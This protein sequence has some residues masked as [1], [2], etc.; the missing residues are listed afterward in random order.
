M[1]SFLA[2]LSVAR[3]LPRQGLASKILLPA[4]S[5][6][7]GVGLVLF[8]FFAD[9]FARQAEEDLQNRLDSFLTTQAAELEG[10]V[11][12]FDQA[13]IDRLFRSYALSSD[14]QLARLTDARGKI[15]A[16]TGQPAPAGNRVFAAG[17]ELTRQ[18]GQDTYQLGRL[19]VVFNDSRIRQGLA[20]SR[21]VELPAAFALAVLFMAV[22][23]LTVHWQVGVPLR[24]LRES[25]E[26]NAATGQR[27]PLSW[28]SGDELGQVVGAYNA[29]LAE[30]N[31]QTGTLERANSE[32]G[33]ENLQRR[34]AEKRLTLY[35]TM[36]EATDTAMVITD[37]E[38]RVQETNAA[39]LRV[40]GFSAGE[41]AGRTVWETFLSDH[42]AQRVAEL[43]RSL[44]TGAGWAGE[45][46]GLTRRGGRVPLRL[47]INALAFDGD[48]ASHHVIVFA[49]ISEQKATQK[50]LKSLAYSDS[51]TGLPNRALFM[52]RLEREICIE[53]RRGR[54]FALL[55]VDLDNFKW[56]N[57]SLSHA[58][59]D[60]VLTVMAGRMKACLR[61][62]DTLARMGGDEFTVILRETSDAE[63]VGRV[64]ETL[65]ARMAEPL[66]VDGVALEASA[67]IGAALYPADGGD[68]ETLMKNADTA[69][70]AAKAA[71]G[72]RLHFFTPVIAQKAQAR[73]DLRKKLRQALTRDE[74]VL[75]FQPI[76]DMAGGGVA[77]YEALVRWNRRQELVAPAQF[78]PFAEDEGLIGRIGRQVF[79]L[80][81]AQLRAWD[82]Q[83]FAATVSVNVSRDQFLE[84]DFVEDL[85]GRVDRHGIDPGRVV[86]EITESLIIADPAV[87]RVVLGQLIVGGFRIAVDD[88]GVGYSSLSVLVEYPV[89]IVKL[90]KSLI[91]TLEC[92]HRARTMVSGFIGLFQNLGLEVVAEG[93]ETALQHEFLFAAGCDMAQGWLYGKPAPA[94]FAPVSAQSMEA[95]LF[96]RLLREKGGSPAQ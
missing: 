27:T 10:A 73:L 34:L 49:D 4:L 7:L 13:A 5:L 54:G 46:R 16:A 52:D 12:E 3:F 90:D 85:L 24:R 43:G 50:L 61:S 47:T 60:R 82:G 55:F 31:Q 15:L 59:G 32:L 37:R 89:H 74:F 36:V 57:D 94:R 95:R 77:H 40:T 45:W 86:L 28:Q 69:M 11:W 84:D 51:L 65:L 42:D 35:K 92:D 44:E 22:L 6:S 17:R 33:A 8:L 21:S 20:A 88:F 39:C 26:R 25:L 63:V 66:D 48:A 58:V 93:V 81:F 53:T 96:T 1:P 68:S 29:L 2:H 56:I 76:V 9:K 91:R 38:L 72:G 78:I 41:V 87:A 30:V 67:S 62:E 19:E 79:D 64:T 80:A 18:A 70:Y 14:L 83:G 23:G 75:H 71:G